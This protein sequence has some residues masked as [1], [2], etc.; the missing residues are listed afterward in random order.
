MFL[1]TCSIMNTSGPVGSDTVHLIIDLSDGNTLEHQKVPTSESLWSILSQFQSQHN[2]NLCRRFNKE[3]R[4]ECPHLH[5]NNFP[6]AGTLHQLCSTTLSAITSRDEFSSK[7]ITLSL[8]FKAAA[9]SIRDLDDKIAQTMAPIKQPQKGPDDGSKEL[10]TDD[11]DV[12]I[13]KM[14]S[15]L[16]HDFAMDIDPEEALSVEEVFRKMEMLL[17]KLTTVL[18]VKEDFVQC[19]KFLKKVVNNMVLNPLNPPSGSNQNVNSKKG[20]ISL[21]ALPCLKMLKIFE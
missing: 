11:D 9:F 8:E 16:D 5:F 12:E 6:I 10:K 20:R 18:V 1:S 13:K 14:D 15:G 2:Y 3:N 4:F 17:Y 21:H 7:S 19:M